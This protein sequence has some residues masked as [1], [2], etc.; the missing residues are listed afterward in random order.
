MVSDNQMLAEELRSL[1]LR[2]VNE[3]CASQIRRALL[4]KTKPNRE[5]V[6][7]ILPGA[8]STFW[9]W[10]KRTGGKKRGIYVLGRMLMR[11]ILMAKA[12]GSKLVATDQV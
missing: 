10:S 5:E 3:M 6:Q 8:P 12:H 11:M 4:R 9:R 2:V 1:A 7:Q